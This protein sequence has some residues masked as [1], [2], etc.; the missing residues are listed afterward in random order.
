MVSA[1]M[2]TNDVPNNEEPTKRQFFMS[3][4]RFFAS[5]CSV[6]RY[7]VSFTSLFSPLGMGAQSP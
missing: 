2:R 5:R 7:A 6:Y 1:A 4:C 3:F